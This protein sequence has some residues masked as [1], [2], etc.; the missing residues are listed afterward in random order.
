MPGHLIAGMLVF[1]ALCGVSGLEI[2]QAGYSPL[3]KDR[4]HRL[5]RS[6]PCIAPAPGRNVR[7]L[8]RHGC[9]RFLFARYPI[10]LPSWEL[11]HNPCVKL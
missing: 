9:L 10:A 8:G 2:N 11:L 5:A 7:Q 6:F 4:V 1:L 3:Q